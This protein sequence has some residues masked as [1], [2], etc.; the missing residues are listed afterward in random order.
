M[1]LV[2]VVA[3]EYDTG[4]GFDWYHSEELADKYFEEEKINCE[5]FWE[6]HWEVRQFTCEFS[7]DL[8]NEEIT[9]AIAANEEELYNAATKR[10]NA[11]T[12]WEENK[13]KDQNTT[14]KI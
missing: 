10:W 7:P 4:G 11:D 6:D 2:Y 13:C 14:T 3:W 12:T 5:E 8:S 9:E 1:K